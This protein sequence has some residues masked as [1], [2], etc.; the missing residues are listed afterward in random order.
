MPDLTPNLGLKKPKG[1]ETVSRAAYNENLDVIDK[2]AARASDLA[3]HQAEDKIQAHLAKNIALEDT[4]GNFTSV[5][6]EGAMSEL[7]TS[8]SDGKSLVASAVTDMGQAANGSDTFSTLAT[9][10]RDVSKDAN[11]GVGDVL[12]SKTF[13]Q[14]GVKRTGTIPSKGVQTYTPGTTSQIIA[15]NQ[16]LTGVQTILGDP[17]LKPENIKSGVSIFDVPG[18]LSA[19]GFIKSIQRGVITIPA[20]SVSATATI[21]SVNISKAIIIL[22]GVTTD[23][24]TARMFPCLTLTDSTTITATREYNYG[25]TTT[26]TYEVVEFSLLT[27]LQRGTIIIPDGITTATATISSVDTSKAVIILTGATT[28]YNPMAMLPYLTLTDSTTVTA[29]RNYTGLGSNGYTTTLNYEVV[30]L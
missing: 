15:A 1:N 10:I 9:K 17:E 21:A 5:E 26:L 7:F 24:D 3:A 29:T 12:A 14:G 11:A 16:Y 13:Y 25:H 4:A 23:Y 27:S 28:N 2:N 22:T 19:S 30:E 20:E 18:N 8:V 6:L